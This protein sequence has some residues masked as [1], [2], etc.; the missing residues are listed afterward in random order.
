MVLPAAAILV[1]VFTAILAPV[2]PAVLTAILS[3]IFASILVAR[4]FVRLAGHGGRGQQ[5]TGHEECTEQ[6]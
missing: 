1:A 5:R 2:F 6:L 3:A 4:R